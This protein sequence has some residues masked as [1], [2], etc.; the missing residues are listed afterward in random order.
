MPADDEDLPGTLQRSPEKAQRTYRAALDSA[1]ETYDSE[2]AAHRVAFA[3]VKH[4]FEKVGDHWEE[5]AEKGP[6]DPQA[7]RGGAEARDHPLPTGGGMV[8]GTTQKE[9]YAQAKQLG[10]PGRSRMSKEELTEAVRKAKR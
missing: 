9:L 8:V 4:N 6:S 7:A 2:A 5:K 1:H 10:I 3:A